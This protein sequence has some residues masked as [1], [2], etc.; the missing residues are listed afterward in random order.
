[1]SI[2]VDYNM[3]V[4]VFY[5]FVCENDNIEKTAISILAIDMLVAN[6]IS[7]NLPSINL[8]KIDILILID[9]I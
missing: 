4:I 7:A 5:F 9:E 1:M 3:T 8:L 2:L 6:L